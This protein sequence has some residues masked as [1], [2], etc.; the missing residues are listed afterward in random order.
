MR[1]GWAGRCRRRPSKWE[2]GSSQ[3]PGGLA[4]SGSSGV[5]DPVLQRA[6]FS[7][8]FETQRRPECSLAADS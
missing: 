2:K 4:D 3:E 1:D 6:A 8:G 7:L 5:I